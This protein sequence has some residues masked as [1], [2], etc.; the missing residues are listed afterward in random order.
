MRGCSWRGASPCAD[1]G[2]GRTHDGGFVF[3]DGSV[4][5]YTQRQTAAPD[6]QT[7]TE[8]IFTDGT[9]QYA[10]NNELTHDNRELRRVNEKLQKMYVRA[11]DQY[12]WGVLME[13]TEETSRLCP[14]RNE[15][16]GDFYP[17]RPV[18]EEIRHDIR[19]IFRLLI[20]AGADRESRSAYS[21][22]AIRQHYEGSPVWVLCGD[23]FD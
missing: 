16:T 14:I 21:G 3:P 15:E 2:I 5:Y 8:A 20:D 23:L 18:T 9:E 6:G 17:G 1:R 22:K 7:Y 13:A 10:A 19:R 12:G 11:T 4:W